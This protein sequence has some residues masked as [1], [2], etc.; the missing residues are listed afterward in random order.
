[1]PL[2]TE[3]LEP[4]CLGERGGGLF[5]V[6]R[7]QE[8]HLFLFFEEGQLVGRIKGDFLF[9]HHIQ[10]FRNQLRQADIS[11]YLSAAVTSFCTDHIGHFQLPANLSGS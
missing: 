4:L 6:H 7:V 11:L 10:Q 9:I 5:A 8:L 1:M 3:F 2:L